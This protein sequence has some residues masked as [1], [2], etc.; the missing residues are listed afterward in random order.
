MAEPVLR[1]AA[2]ERARARWRTGR[3]EAGAPTNGLHLLNDPQGV[4]PPD[5]FGFL[6]SRRDDKRVALKE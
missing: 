2:R 3:G 6:L 4:L 5:V 1:A